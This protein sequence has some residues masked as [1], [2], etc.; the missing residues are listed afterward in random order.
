MDKETITSAAYP[1]SQPVTGCYK[2][3][4]CACISII[5]EVRGVFNE[6]VTANL[7]TGTTI[8]NDFDGCGLG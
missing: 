8:E 4:E 1:S 6:L 7:Y 3:S 2:F 5:A